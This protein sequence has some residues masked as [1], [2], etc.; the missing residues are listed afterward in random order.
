MRLVLVG[1]CALISCKADTTI[2]EDEMKANVILFTTS[3]KRGNE[4]N[5]KLNFSKTPRLV[6][7]PIEPIVHSLTP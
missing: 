7:L 1:S 6:K 4:R 3:P 2:I 5:S